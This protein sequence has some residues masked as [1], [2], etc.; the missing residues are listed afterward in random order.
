[1]GFFLHLL[2]VSVWK[3]LNTLSYMK[4]FSKCKNKHISLLTYNNY[5]YYCP[6]VQKEVLYSVKV[7]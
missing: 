7:L 6:T 5:W 2:L 3:L 4:I 1:M